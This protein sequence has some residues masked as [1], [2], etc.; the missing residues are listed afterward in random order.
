[1]HYLALLERKPGALD[2]ARPL[3]NWALP[4]SVLLLRRRLE[5]K[6]GHMGTHEF[7]KCMRLLELCSVAQLARAVE[8]TQELGQATP[9]SSALRVILDGL[10]EPLTSPFCLDG[11]LHLTEVRVDPPDLAGYRQLLEVNGGAA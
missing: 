11:R 9:D 8:V 1:M 2:F 3:E 5:A 6:L 7:I 4:E 10:G